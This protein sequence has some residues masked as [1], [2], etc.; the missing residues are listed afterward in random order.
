MKKHKLAKLMSR[1]IPV[2]IGTLLV[3]LWCVMDHVI[4]YPC[5]VSYCMVIWLQ[6]DVLLLPGL[7]L[8]VGPEIPAV[9]VMFTEL[10]ISIAYSSGGQ[11]EIIPELCNGRSSWRCLPTPAA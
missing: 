11:T 5:I 9:K 1:N 2:L 7:L 6:Y 3:N 4:M 10:C 8:F